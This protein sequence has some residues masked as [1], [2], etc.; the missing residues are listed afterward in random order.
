MYMA[1]LK[2]DF[3]KNILV[4]VWRTLLQKCLLILQAYYYF[5]YYFILF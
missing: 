1:H 3:D 4:K 2:N 5:Y